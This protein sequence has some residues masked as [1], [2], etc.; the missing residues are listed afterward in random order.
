MAVALFL[1][2]CRFAAGGN[3]RLV[4]YNRSGML[5]GRWVA[6]SPD[7]AFCSSTCRNFTGDCKTAE[8]KLL[9]YSFLLVLLSLFLW[10]I[11]CCVLCGRWLE[12]WAEGGAFWEGCCLSVLR[13]LSKTAVSLPYPRPLGMIYLTAWWLVPVQMPNSCVKCTVM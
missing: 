12:E 3:Y 1:W 6:H 9:I 13:Q 2:R 10:I 8:N 5:I 7:H 11:T 4:V